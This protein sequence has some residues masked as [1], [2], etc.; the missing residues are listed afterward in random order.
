MRVGDLNCCGASLT[1]GDAALSLDGIT[2]NGD[3][4]LSNGFNCLGEIRLPGAHVLGNLECISATIGNLICH[5]MTIDGEFHVGRY[6]QYGSGAVEPCWGKGQGSA[7]PEE[8]LAFLGNLELEGLTYEQLT[9]HEDPGKVP[10]PSGN[11]PRSGTR[12]SFQIIISG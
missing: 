5:N 11:S 12:E 2:V 7:R 6:R 10:P 1:S 4:L 3:L 8:Q 9:V